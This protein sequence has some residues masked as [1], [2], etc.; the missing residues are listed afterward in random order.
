MRIEKAYDVLRAASHCHVPL[1]CHSCYCLKL[2]ASF[3]CFGSQH[4]NHA[5]SPYRNAPRNAQTN[6]YSCECK[7]GW[8]GDGYVTAG[9]LKD[10][11]YWIER[12]RSTAGNI[13]A[14]QD[15]D[16]CSP[17][18]CLNG[19]SHFFFQNTTKKTRVCKYEKNRENLHF[20][21]YFFNLKL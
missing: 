14:C 6:R 15:I 13:Q 5:P 16:D 19:A 3:F 9:T 12:A 20:W 8:E 21:K 1:T 7:P 2:N 11:P 4:I 10:E 18:P 17:A